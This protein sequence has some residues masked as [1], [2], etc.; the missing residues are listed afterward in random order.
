LSAVLAACGS[1]SAKQSGGRTQVIVA[2]TDAAQTARFETATTIHAK[3]APAS[4]QTITGAV[5]F[6]HNRGN[7]TLRASATSEMPF[8]SPTAKPKIV[9]TTAEIRWDGTVVYEN[10]GGMGAAYLSVVRLP[11][12]RPWLKIDLGKVAASVPCLKDLA[13][14]GT[15]SAI[16]GSAIPGGF[17]P[18]SAIDTLRASGAKLTEVGTSSVRGETA[19][20]WRVSVPPPPATPS[21]CGDFQRAPAPDTTSLDIW[22]DAQHRLVRTRTTATQDMNDVGTSTPETSMPGDLVTSTQTTDFFDFGSPVAVSSPDPATVFDETPDMVTMALG[23][24]AVA[25]SAWHEAANGTFAGQPWTVWAAKSA[26]GWH[27]YDATGLPMG[28]ADI[29]VN[30]SAHPPKHDGR[31]ATCVSPTRGIFAQPRFTLLFAGPDGDHSALLGY[32]AGPVGNAR[33]QFVD[34]SSAAL[35]VDPSTG[36]AQWT[37]APDQQP[38]HVIVDGESCSLLFHAVG[39][40]TSSRSSYVPDKDVCQGASPETTMQQFP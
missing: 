13:T 14:S 4:T 19:T 38:A 35:H 6:T 7:A 12:G 23:V 15:A 39:S 10:L 8:G 32:T 2:A 34:G 20:H 25:A 31:D 21:I 3:G 29:S 1:T 40:P 5:D 26:A 24:G 22:T 27:C 11:A 17:T 28:F 9:T 36:L 33:I 37:G 18:T 16:V 30:D